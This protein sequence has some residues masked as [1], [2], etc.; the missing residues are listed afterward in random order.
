MHEVRNKVE[1]KDNGS[2]TRYVPPAL[3]RSLGGNVLT[4]QSRGEQEDPYE[5]E[6]KLQ[7]V[8]VIGYTSVTDAESDHTAAATEGSPSKPDHPHAGEIVHTE[9][10]K[11]AKPPDAGDGSDKPPQKPPVI[12]GAAEPGEPEDPPKENSDR[13]ASDNNAHVDTSES[14][15]VITAPDESGDAGSN[16][17]NVDRDPGSPQRELQVDKLSEPIDS[18]GA[19]DPYEDFDKVFPENV[20]EK[21]KAA[22][23]ELIRKTKPDVNLDDVYVSCTGE[24]ELTDA[25]MD[26]ADEYKLN[27]ASS[28]P[29]GG[30]VPGEFFEEHN[31]Y[32]HDMGHFGF[33]GDDSNAR[34]IV[35]RDIQVLRDRKGEAARNYE[36]LEIAGRATESDREQLRERLAHLDGLITGLKETLPDATEPVYYATPWSGLSQDDPEH[37]PL[38]YAGRLPESPEDEPATTRLVF[39]DAASLRAA[40]IQTAWKWED[41]QVRILGRGRDIMQHALGVLEVPFR[42]T[43]DTESDDDY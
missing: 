24:S 3:S 15:P 19:Y 22:A 1:A 10:D 37:N 29:E 34:N 18:R 31:G 20:R 43:E 39:Y 41:G 32:D 23:E 36:A 38:A 17:E 16:P 25:A 7:T 26:A 40:G 12:D 28:V 2:Q 9:A 27:V 13:V 11:D 6:V 33:E 42:S 4:D 30:R 35:I 14:A 5:T 8:K 21:I